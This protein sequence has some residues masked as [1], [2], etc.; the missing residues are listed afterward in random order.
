MKRT[1]TKKTPLKG[2]NA[3]QTYKIQIRPLSLNMAYVGRRFSTDALKSFKREMAVLL[4][5]IKV[6]TGKLMVTYKFG[7]SSKA[8]DADN[9]AKATTDCIAECYGFNDR[10]IYKFVIEKEDVKKGAE[11]IQFEI[12]EYL[13][14]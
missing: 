5:R 2:K 3:P 12:Q 11:F 14:L 10:I 13:T 9:L 4:P 8:S 6:P 7:V 1:L